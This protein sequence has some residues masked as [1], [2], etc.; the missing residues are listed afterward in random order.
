MTASPTLQAT[1]AASGEPKVDLSVAL[2]NP[3]SGGAISMQV[4]L[5]GGPASRLS[6]KLYTKALTVAYQLDVEGNF[7]TGWVNL[8]G[9]RPS[10]LSSGLYYAIVTAKGQAASSQGP[11]AKIMLLNP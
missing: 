5:S 9:P 4:L 6:L 2:P 3:Q 10:S 7:S 11:T 1:T 8:S